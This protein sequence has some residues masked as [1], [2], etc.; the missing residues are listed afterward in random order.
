MLNSSSSSTASPVS[1]SSAVTF[2]NSEL[3]LDK[4]GKSHLTQL[5]G[6]QRNLAQKDDPAFKTM[7]GS[8]NAAAVSLVGSDKQ[9]LFTHGIFQP[10]SEV[11]YVTQVCD[12]L[13]FARVMELMK[14]NYNVVSPKNRLEQLRE[15]NS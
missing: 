6:Q 14:E 11:N 12:N 2:K 8:D 5:N 7:D 4:K 15:I 10:D 9:L 1:S 3:R 13:Q